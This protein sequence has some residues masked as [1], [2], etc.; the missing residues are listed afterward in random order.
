MFAIT[1]FKMQVMFLQQHFVC[2]GGNNGV[3][4]PVQGGAHVFAY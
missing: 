4:R 1:P 3:P 2:G